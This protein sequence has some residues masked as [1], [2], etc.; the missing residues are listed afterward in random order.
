MVKERAKILWDELGLDSCE[1]KTSW[2]E[3]GDS[4]LARHA[5]PTSS[6]A[7]YRIESPLSYYLHQDDYK[8]DAGSEAST[9][10]D[11]GSTPSRPPNHWLWETIMTA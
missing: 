8:P 1:F 4:L 3:R 2:T 5:V 7:V 9:A 10:S 11:Q 6:Q